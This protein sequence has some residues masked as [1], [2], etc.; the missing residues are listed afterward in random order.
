MKKFFATLGRELVDRVVISHKSTI[1][2]W[3]I[4]GAVYGVDQLALALT[5][6]H[7]PYAPLASLAIGTIGTAL[8]DKEKVAAVR[9]AQEA[10][11][12]AV[13]TAALA[14]LVGGAL[15][16]AAPARADDA[17]Q[18]KLGGGCSVTK[19][20]GEFCASPDVAVQVVAFRPSGPSVGFSPGAGYKLELFAERWYTLGL[21]A[22]IAIQDGGGGGTVSGLGSFAHYI[23]AGVA[24][25]LYRRGGVY[26]VLGLGMDLGPS[27]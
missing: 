23:R 20:L 25:D 19:S 13:K 21:G 22:Y 2:S 11:K 12:A 26:P 4:G 27:R 18:S 16:F 9:A 3:L 14:L 17:T 1:I 7:S 6:W 24:K 10:A 5:G 15:L 8:K